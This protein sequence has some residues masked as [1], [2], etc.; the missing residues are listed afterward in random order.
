[1]EVLKREGYDVALKEYLKMDKP[2]LGICLGMQTLFESSQEC[3]HNGDGMTSTVIEGLGVIPGKVVKFNEQERSVPHIGWNGA[4]RHQSSP[5]MRYIHDNSHG[6]EVYFVHSYYAPLTAENSEWVL[7]RTTYEGQEFIS[8]VQK[9]N[10][11]ATQ[12]HPEKSGVTGLNF[13]R[14]FLDSVADG[15]LSNTQPLEVDGSKHTELVKRVVVAL[16]VRSNDHGDLVVTKGDQYD[17]R[18]NE[19]EGVQEGRGGVRNLGKPVSLASRYYKEGA[20]EIAFLNIT[21]FRSGVIEDMPMLQVL[22]EASKEIFVPLTVG[23]GIRSYEDPG[24]GKV[25]SALEVASRYFRA[26]ADKVSI[27]SDS[28]HAAAEY[29][30]SG[31]TKTG[32]TSIETIS[33]VY[34]V[35]AVVIS[36]DP[37]RVYVTS[38]DAADSKHTVV[39]LDHS[40]KGPNGEQYCWYQ[41]T[42]KGGREA[43]DICAV[44]VAK[45]AEALGAGE[46]MLNCIDMDGQC[47]G[48]D[49]ALMKAVSDAVT[50]PVIA[51]S[52]AG[53]ESHFS[54]VFSETSVQAA[55]AAGMFHRKEVEIADVKKHME[56]MGIRARI[57]G[58]SLA[59]TGTD[60]GESFDATTEEFGGWKSEYERQLLR[61]TCFQKYFVVANFWFAV[62]QAAVRM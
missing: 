62:E 10:V 12:F 23:G 39:T 4:L 9:G 44:S 52:G 61:L 48:F 17:V 51:S 2:F 18:E 19:K 8:S 58:T 11:V 42:V 7:T 40:Q 34:G 21:S 27:G 38:P 3:G 57:T 50:I 56:K 37:K 41:C 49:H 31:N 36:I 54:D 20:D 32:Q 30:A 24:T 14:G 55:L 60:V 35:Q 22:E 28:V 29:I 45:A 25:Y 47:N 33:H 16:D 26:G 59:W 1:M 13:I 43:R 53:K 6:E 15:T 5:C 46:I